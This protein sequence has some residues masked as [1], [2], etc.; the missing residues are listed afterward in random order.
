MKSESAYVKTVSLFRK[1]GIGDKTALI[2]GTWFGSGLM[3]MASGTFGTL[4]AIPLAALAGLLSPAAAFQFLAVMILLAFWVAG[5]VRNL[6][7]TEDPGAVVID[8]VVGLLTTLL[9]ISV[10]WTTLI[11]GFVLFRIF[12]IWKPWPAGPAE[13]IHGG[14]GI[15]LDDLVA[16]VYANLSLRVIL[17]FGF[18]S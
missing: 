4:A 14:V 2:L 10:S 17:L 15:V 12:D 16:G 3:P 1:S 9:W 11:L 8:E 5:K 13:K 7:E 6:L 18:F